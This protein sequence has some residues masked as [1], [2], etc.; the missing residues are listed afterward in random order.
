MNIDPTK[1]ELTQD[2]FIAICGAGLQSY[3]SIGAIVHLTNTYGNLYE[4]IDV[5]H[6]GTTDTVDIICHTQVANRRMDAN[7]QD[8]NTSELRSWL[9]T[10]YLNAFDYDIRE[11]MKTM[12]VTTKGVTNYD[13]VKLLSWRELGLNYNST[14]MY[15]TDG[16]ERYPVFTATNYNTPVPARWKAP[17]TYGNSNY[18]QFRSAV[19]N[20]ASYIWV[21]TSIGTTDPVGLYYNQAYGVIPVLRF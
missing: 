14:Y 5:N 17:G 12:N 10:D 16:G 13:K 21:V 18:A 2:E 7:S 20:N 19:V 1:M 8:Y 6:D 9:N 4:V 15:S 11:L 3:M